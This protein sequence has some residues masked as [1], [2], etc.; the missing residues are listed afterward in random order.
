MRTFDYII[1]GAGS[2][3]CVLAERLSADPRNQVLLI[4]AG[5]DYNNMNLKI[6]MG[7]SRAIATPGLMW[8]YATEPEEGTANQT[9]V[10]G[11]GKLVGGSSSINGMIY[12]RGNPD[13]YDGWE[14]LGAR[15]WG[16][17]DIAP[18]FRAIER[19]EL[20][21]D[22]LRGAEGPVG[23]TINRHRS[24]LNSAILTAAGDL[25]LPVKEDVNRLEQEGIG[26]TPV[27]IWKGRRVSSATAFLA[28]AR[29]R[30]NL[31]VLAQTNA[32]RILFNGTRA[33]VLEC[34]SGQTPVTFGI[35]KELIISS[36]TI[37][38]PKLLQLSGIGP[39]KALREL[40]I[41]VIH[42]NPNVGTHLREHKNVGQIYRL[43][44]PYSHNVDLTGW[45]LALNALRYQLFRTG[46]LATVTD[47]IGFIKTRP[48]LKIPD[49]QLMFWSLS[50]NSNLVEGV[51]LDEWPGIWACTWPLRPESQGELMIRSSNPADPPIIRP[52]FL[53][54]E[55]DRQ[56]LIASFRFMRK[57][58][59]HPAVAPMIAAEA[60]PGDHVQTDDEILDWIKLQG[61]CAHATGT[62]AMGVEGQSVVDER[63][64]VRGVSGVR[65]V[66]C[67]IM[68]TQISGNPNGP[69]M[70]L[71]WRAAQLILEDQDSTVS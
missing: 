50:L 66:D 22:G 10:W 14:R 31:T 20:G 26:Y 32:I 27:T 13:D 34:L 37:E 56:I 25:G 39:A 46:P 19:H 55:S 41:D 63:L 48:E 5:P 70:A 9:R 54:A 3:G 33:T 21:D 8:N 51:R 49:A 57:I 28:P 60:R 11:R 15:G 23:I 29:K 47:I 17:K 64:R 52:N 69:A 24:P 45:R 65:V 36:G 44:V 16:W 71:A 68:P 6:P 18:C 43:S 30:P 62:C 1:I 58:F 67:S 2:S 40:G 35:G 61:T 4:E 42:D 53:S 7:M 38:S 59:A 12:T